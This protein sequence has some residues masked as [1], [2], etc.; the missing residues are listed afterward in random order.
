M[1]G[2]GLP[3]SIQVGREIDGVGFLGQAAQLLDDLFFAGQDL[4]LGLPAMFRIDAHARDQLTLGLLLGRQRGRFGRRSLAALDRLL[5]GRAA[6]GKVADVADTRLH[7]VL[8]AQILVDCL[9]LG[10]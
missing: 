9:G 7:H 1:P 10:R 8:V 2:D 6:G 4:V 3:F 5:V